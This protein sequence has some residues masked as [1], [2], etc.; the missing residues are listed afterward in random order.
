MDSI[1]QILRSDGDA[2]NREL[3]GDQRKD[4]RDGSTKGG[5][6]E[7]RGGST[8]QVRLA[9]SGRE[10]ARWTETDRQRERGREGGREW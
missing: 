2:E 8:Q 1:C 9:E 3:S 5:D 4:E 7:E 10:R 6:T